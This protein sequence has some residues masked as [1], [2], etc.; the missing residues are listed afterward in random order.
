MR[1]LTGSLRRRVAVT[2][3]LG[4]LLLC[5]TF[6]IAAYSITR[7]NL[8]DQRERTVV[9]RAYQDARLL[10]DQLATAGTSPA[11]ALA[12]LPA[13]G[14][15]AVVLYHRGRW[16]STSLDIGSTAIPPALRATTQPDGQG[17][18]VAYLTA[19]IV[20]QPRLVVGV[21]IAA[22]DAV[23]Y[24][25]AP[26]GELNAALRTLGT[27]LTAG[28]L[29]ATALAALVGAQLA[30]QVL[31]PLRPLSSTAVAIAAGDLASPSGSPPPA[32]AGAAHP[33]PG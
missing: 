26:L 24:E 10:R 31:R 13:P 16:Y 9:R 1:W 32:G 22:V 8:I 6:A 2:F 4:G 7:G 27:V 17:G 14:T 3:A 29:T 21:P 20:G 33:A 5:A 11:D 15:T 12:T 28:T 23:V 19:R 30:R 18:Q 25:V